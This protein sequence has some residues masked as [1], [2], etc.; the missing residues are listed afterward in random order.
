[1]DKLINP[2][3]FKIL[4][5]RFGIS[6]H[7]YDRFRTGLFDLPGNRRHQF[8]IGIVSGANHYNRRFGF[9]GCLRRLLGRVKP[10]IGDDVKPGD[11]EESAGKIG[12][13]FMLGNRSHIGQK[14]R[15]LGAGSV[16]VIF[17]RFAQ[18]FKHLRRPMEAKRFDGGCLFTLRTNSF[19][20][21]TEGRFSKSGRDQAFH[22][23][24]P[25]G[26]GIL[27]KTFQRGFK[28]VFVPVTAEFF[29]KSNPLLVDSRVVRLIIFQRLFA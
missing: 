13:G 27:R 12:P 9:N 21:L 5:L 29:Q 17:H 20:H 7:N 24:S 6:G 11:P 22:Q 10:G 15:G 19:C 23:F 16:L 3:R 1:M 14:D 26:V 2:G 8:G 18:I 25:I 4:N 28:F